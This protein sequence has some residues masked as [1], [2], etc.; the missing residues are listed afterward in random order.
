MPSLRGSCASRR[1]LAGSGAAPASRRAMKLPPHGCVRKAP[2]SERGGKRDGNRP[3]VAADARRLAFPHESP[4]AL[5]RNNHPK[6]PHGAAEPGFAA[7]GA[8]GGDG[9]MVERPSARIRPLHF[10]LC[11]RRSCRCKLLWRRPGWLCSMA[12]RCC[13]P[14]RKWTASRQ[15]CWPAI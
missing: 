3:L 15:S 14:R 10:R 13:P 2:L 9:G 7:G 8:S 4:E 5:P 1:G 6:L 11:P 12:S